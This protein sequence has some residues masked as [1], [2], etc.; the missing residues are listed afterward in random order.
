MQKDRVKLVFVLDDDF[1][2]IA[3]SSV[4]HVQ[5]SGAW[6]TLAF[7]AGGMFLRDLGVDDIEPVSDLREYLLK[8]VLIEEHP[9]PEAVAQGAMTFY[10]LIQ[11]E[12]QAPYLAYLEQ[13][14]GYGFI[15]SVSDPIPTQTLRVVGEMMI[16]QAG[17]D[18]HLARVGQLRRQA[19]EIAA[20][21]K[22]GRGFVVPGQ[23]G[24]PPMGTVPNDGNGGVVKLP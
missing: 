21:Q 13:S 12:K 2:V 22:G 18:A 17:V 6:P 23:G 4:A 9:V 20:Q 10:E 11:D 3:Q 19:M 16:V 5:E 24:V 15:V 8:E 7:L 14:R 1:D